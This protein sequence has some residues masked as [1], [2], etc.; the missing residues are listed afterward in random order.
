MSEQFDQGL[1]YL[2]FIQHV[3]ETSPSSQMDLFK[4]A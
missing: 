2:T 1:H 4:A 3:L